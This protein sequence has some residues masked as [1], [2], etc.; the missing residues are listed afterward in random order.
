M[1]HRRWALWLVPVLALAMVASACSDDDDDTAAGSSNGGP[2]TL[3]S[4]LDEKTLT[5][6]MTLQFKPEMY[7]DDA[8]NP[9]GYD[10]ELVQ[11]LAE[12]LG[13]ELKI[14]NQE[15]D[16]LIP[17]LLAGK[18]DMISVGLVPRPARLLQMNFT[19]AY[20]PYEQVLAV[21]ADDDSPPTIDSFNKSGVTL[22][23]LQGATAA[24]QVKTQFPDATLKEFP[25]Q[26]GA[27]LEVA[28]GRAQGIVVESYLA[29]GF[30]KA[31][32]GKLKVVALPAPLQIE[33]GS[34]A[35]PKGDHE[36]LTYLNSWL[37]YY[38]NNG[39]LDSE[40]V[41]IFASDPNRPIWA[42]G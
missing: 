19:D 34:W 12:D 42:R 9:A 24:E 32:P 33:Y 11:K 16:A 27:F 1:K 3:Q 29:D 30:I 2:N 23:A 26:D 15:F 8:N 17:G 39:F 21:A 35:I 22:T 25:Q 5:V 6:G 18:W 38:K 40:Y 28:S 7:L 14:E 10:V 41:K 13:V 20:V 36:F 31:N 37:Q 4:V